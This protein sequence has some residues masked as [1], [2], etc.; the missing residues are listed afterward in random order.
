VLGQFRGHNLFGDLP[1]RLWGRDDDWVLRSGEGAV[2]VTGKKPRGKGWS[3][4]LDYEPDG[5]FW[6]EVTG[7]VVVAGRGLREGE[8][9]GA[10]EAAARALTAPADSHGPPSNT[11]RTSGLATGLPVVEEFELR[12]GMVCGP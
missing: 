10:R 5:R 1:E 2:W 8:E 4:E 11:L 12:P 9:R 3:L 6:L 7:E